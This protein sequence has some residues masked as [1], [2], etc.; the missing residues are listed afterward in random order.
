MPGPKP[1]L[2]DLGTVDIGAGG[3][4]TPKNIEYQHGWSI[5]AEVTGT[6]GN[7]DYTLKVAHTETGTYYDYKTA[8]GVSL[9]DAIQDIQLNWCWVKISVNAGGGSSGTAS[10][11]MK[12]KH[13]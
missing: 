7:A 3:E 5:A 1:I 11:T 8:I 4:T 13:T 2:L 6:A 12:L 10:F 9:A